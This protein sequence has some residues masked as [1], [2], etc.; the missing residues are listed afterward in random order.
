MPDPAAQIA[1]LRHRL[2]EADRLYRLGEPTG[3]S[4]QDWDHALKQ[5]EQLEADHPDAAADGLDNSP[6]QRV[7][8]EP[9]AGF[10]TVE[11]SSPM[12]SIDNT[13][14]RAELE[15]WINRTAKTL[16][17]EQFDMV[18]EPK[19]DGVALALRYEH[20]RLT[21]AL[22]RGDGTKGDDIT[23]N[24]KTVRSIPLQLSY[25][26]TQAVPERS[27]G[28]DQPAG[29]IP[30]VL[31][32]RGEIFMPEDVFAKLNAQREAEGQELYA[33]PR[34][35]TAG[36]LKQKDPRKVAPGLQF[37][38]YG[39]GQVEPDPFETHTDFTAALK[40]LGVPIHEHEDS[41]HSADE[42]WAWIER[43]DK[44]RHTLPYATDGVV[45]KVN[46]YDQQ[47]QLGANSKAPRWCI[48]Y[49]FAAE[50]ATTKLLEVNWQVGKTGKLTPRATME[51][52]F[53]AG[54]TVT[55]ATL[56][57]YGEVLRKGI[58]LGD[59]VTIE[60]AGE[61]IPQV[62]SA[63]AEERTGQEQ[64]IVPPDQ[65]PECKTPVDIENDAR[66]INELASHERKVEREKAKAEKEDRPPEPI[67]PPSPLGTEDETARYCPN[68]ECPA[69]FRERLIHFVGRNQMDIDALGEKTIHQLAD[70]GLL[71]NLGDI[72]TLKDHRDRL[73]ELERMGEKKV[74]NLIAGVEEAK[75]RGLRRVLA[76]LTIRH[77][78]TGGAKR[79]SQHFGS[80]DALMEADEETI[81]SIEDVGPITAASVH[82]FL[83]N[84]AGRRV[85]Q[86]LKTHGV[87]LTEEIKRPTPGSDPVGDDNPFAG[88]TIVLTGTL[89]HYKRN[90]L[91]TILEDLGAKV[92]GSISK[93]TDLL[94]AGEKAG[95]KLTKAQSLG[96]EV[97]NE[98]Q[99][100]ENLPQAK[101]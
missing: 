99:L 78:G 63:V 66:R 57:N 81:A 90:D 31:E 88:K 58:M 44:L 14:S 62:V 48:A 64:S 101:A 82:Q 54:T 9:I 75:S 71:K 33:N 39:K 20:G 10:N 68:P 24:I 67:A 47:Q 49:K 6:T 45:I 29:S 91:K 34:N 46:R 2:N 36:N 97:W 70:A 22:T 5:L 7:G 30:P 87:D 19:V 12:L 3:M 37:I 35:T 13:Y 100:L 77:V 56:H 80:I 42:A 89:E 52:V 17:V 60:K 96:V 92:S 18:L 79:L 50:Q 23:H 86:E 59:T 72:F 41:V 55:H 74:D 84:P 94:I 93:N 40:T 16:G 98:A 83:D 32:T 65:C 11:H 21:Q 95:S 76:G 26:N 1:D 27:E 8:G 69:Q 38:A 85:I 53:L 4:D 43:F 15:N 25:S 61:I 73:L 51:P 28:A